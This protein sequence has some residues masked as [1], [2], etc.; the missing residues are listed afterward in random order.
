MNSLRPCVEHKKTIKNTERIEKNVIIRQIGCIQP[1]TP[2]PRITEKNPH[3]ELCLKKLFQQSASL[4]WAQLS[5][6]QLSVEVVASGN[7]LI[8]HI[9]L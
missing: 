5:V 2:E 3:A 7:E 1:R 8:C 4:T 6:S 9:A